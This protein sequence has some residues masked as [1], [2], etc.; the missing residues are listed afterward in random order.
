M[1]VPIVSSKQTHPLDMLDCF[2]NDF[3]H[4]SI[5]QGATRYPG[6]INRNA[7]SADGDPDVQPEV[8]NDFLSKFGTGPGAAANIF[9]PSDVSNN[10][11]QLTLDRFPIQLSE[12][13]KSVDAGLRLT[14]YG[15]SHVNEVIEAVDP[16]PTLYLKLMATPERAFM[17]H[18]PLKAFQ[19]KVG[20][21]FIFESTACSPGLNSSLEKTKSN[22]EKQPERTKL[23]STSLD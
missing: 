15:S 5:S 8:D 17:L 10:Q 21:S 4:H 1:R 12:P 19:G 6:P 18:N 20:T 7:S 22:L 14:R 13:A 3:G 2:S 9:E 23:S 16:Q 11:H